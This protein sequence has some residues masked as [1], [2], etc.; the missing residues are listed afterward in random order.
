MS[1]TL[2]RKITLTAT[3]SAVALILSFFSFSIFPQ[4]KHLTYDLC[5]VV[6]LII[7]FM[8]GPFFGAASSLIVSAVQCVLPNGSNLYGFIMNIASTF[9]LVIPASIIYINMKSKKGAVIGLYSGVV[10]M[11]LM[12]VILNIYITPLFMHVNVEVVIG[13]LP[14]I[15]AFNV[16]KSVLNSIITIFVYKRI[17]NIFKNEN[18]GFKKKD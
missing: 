9:S 11:I 7:S 10:T 2:L 16:V 17:S 1:K 14:F 8:F 3:L 12:M 5:D 4:V 6:I 15:I 18:I 13:L